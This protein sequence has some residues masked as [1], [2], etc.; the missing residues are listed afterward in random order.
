MENAVE[1]AATANIF[2]LVGKILKF[3]PGD[4]KVYTFLDQVAE[5]I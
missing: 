3:N 1:A 4:E 5:N 2:L